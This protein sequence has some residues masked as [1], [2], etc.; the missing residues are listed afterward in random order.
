MLNRP[1]RTSA[2]CKHSGR[3]LPSKRQNQSLILDRRGGSGRFLE[4]GTPFGCA[5]SR[6]LMPSVPHGGQPHFAAAGPGM[7]P[8]GR[9]QGD[10]VRWRVW[11]QQSAAGAINQDRGVAKSAERR[12]VPSAATGS[13]AWPRP[14]ARREQDTSLWPC[15]FCLVSKFGGAK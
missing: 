13:H 12:A 5:R 3:C 14:L 4:P 8:W 6:S 15:G 11:P 1:R 10:R 9:L 7:L 2:P